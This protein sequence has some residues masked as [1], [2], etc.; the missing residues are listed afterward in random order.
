MRSG[1]IT[2]YRINLIKRIGEERVNFIEGDHQPKK[3][4][5]EEII[6]IKKTYK[7]KQ[8]ELTKERHED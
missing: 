6:E 1:N 8:R 5:I 3:Y 7:E 2:D 4:T